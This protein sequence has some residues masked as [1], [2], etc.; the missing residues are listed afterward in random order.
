MKKQILSVMTIGLFVAI[1]FTGMIRLS[2][3]GN[4]QPSV[5]LKPWAC[6]VDPNP[7]FQGTECDVHVIIKNVGTGG[8]Q[9]RFT[10]YCSLDGLPYPYG[11]GD[12]LYR[13]NTSGLGAGGETDADFTF[14]WPQDSNDHTIYIWTDVNDN[15]S[16]Y[17]ETDNQRIFG[18]WQ[19]RK[20]AG[21]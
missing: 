15:V 5:N 4:Q 9:T 14:T 20:S 12:F 17:N 18:P 8:T 6:T 10:T 16:E 1:T 3:A 7:P 13:F 11:N 21:S 19:G 2:E